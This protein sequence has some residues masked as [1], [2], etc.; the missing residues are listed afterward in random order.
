[1]TP[2]LPLIHLEDWTVTRVLILWQNKI[3]SVGGKHLLQ[4]EVIDFVRFYQFNTLQAA[5][6]SPN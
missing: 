6:N 5:F 2:F 4:C 3:F 1:M